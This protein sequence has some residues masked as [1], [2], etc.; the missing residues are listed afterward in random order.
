MLL[1]YLE[2][3][4]CIESTTDSTYN[5]KINK[6]LKEDRQRVRRVFEEVAN[7]LT[8]ADPHSLTLVKN[9]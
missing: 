6:R 3:I 8:E 2:V 9:S 7:L 4:D 1:K 5:S